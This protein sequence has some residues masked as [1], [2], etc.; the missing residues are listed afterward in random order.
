MA[1][2]RQI[3][4]YRR[5]LAK[6]TGT[7]QLTTECL[8]AVVQVGNVEADPVLGTLVSFTQRQRVGLFGMQLA[9]D[10]V[11]CPTCVGRSA[12]CSRDDEIQL[13]DVWLLT[14]TRNATE[15]LAAAGIELA[16]V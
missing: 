11:L 8:G 1:T 4:A 16:V 9:T 13:K 6:I 5:R 15:D 2:L 10:V 3:D 7:A 14:I 12:D